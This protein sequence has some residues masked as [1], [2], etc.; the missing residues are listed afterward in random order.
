MSRV[1]ELL[2]AEEFIA[3]AEEFAA[4]PRPGD[5]DLL[6]E[7]LEQIDRDDEIS[8]LEASLAI[9]EALVASRPRQDDAHLVVIE[10]LRKLGRADDALAFAAANVD[11]PAVRAEHYQLLCLHGRL[12]QAEAVLPSLAGLPAAIGNAFYNL[13][14][15]LHGS[16]AKDRAAAL[17]RA[18]VAV[19]APAPQAA[20]NLGIALL[21]LGRFAEAGE[22]ARAALVKYPTEPNLLAN[23]IDAG[24]RSGDRSGLR[25]LL[26]AAANALGKGSRCK[27][28]GGNAPASCPAGCGALLEDMANAWIFLGDDRSAVMAIEAACGEEEP[29]VPR[30]RY[31]LARA[32]AAGGQVADAAALVRG[33]RGGEVSATLSSSACLA[34]MDTPPAVPDAGSFYSYRA[35]AAVAWAAG[36]PERAAGALC[37]ALLLDPGGRDQL[38]Q[39]ASW[40]ALRGREPS[41]PEPLRPPAVPAEAWWDAGDK[42]W[43]LGPRDKQNGA[44]K[45]FRP[46]GSCC[47]ESSRVD[48]K[49]HGPFL[50]FHE[51]GEVSQRGAFESGE[52]HGTR[53]W[54]A[55]DEATTENTRQD[56]MS[57]DIWASE[58]DYV[59]GRVVEIRH[60]DKAG[61]QVAADGTRYPE[62]PDAVEPRAAYY[63]EKKH[64]RFGEIDAEGKKRGVWRTWNEHGRLIKEESYHDDELHGPFRAFYGNGSLAAEGE[65]ADGEQ[66]G[67]FTYLRNPSP[68]APIVRDPDED[69]EDDDDEDHTSGF[70]FPLAGKRVVKIQQIDDRRHHYDAAGR[71]TL[72]DGRPL[73][74]AMRDPWVGPW[75]TDL[76]KVD[77]S[78]LHSAGGANPPGYNL[79]SYLLA[80]DEDGHE[81]LSD[82]A[83]GGLYWHFCHQGTVYSG[84]AAV[85]PFVIR[86]LERKQ[87]PHRGALCNFLRS[88]GGPMRGAYQRAQAE[89]P[90]EGWADFLGAIA[91]FGEGYPVYRRLLEDA[92]PRIRS[93][94]ASLLGSCHGQAE[95]AARTLSYRLIGEKDPGVRGN[96]LQSL[97]S[98]GADGVDLILRRSLGQGGI[99]QISAGIG[100]AMCKGEDAGIETVA[101]L[102][103]SLA[104]AHEL[105]EAFDAMPWSELNIYAELANTL[106][107]VGNGA[108]VLDEILPRLDQVDPISSISIARAALTIAQRFAGNGEDDDDD[109][110]D[111]DDRGD[112][113]AAMRKV[114]RAIAAAEAPWR[115][116]VNLSEVL[117]EFD[118]PADREELA[119]AAQEE[120]AASS[121]AGAS[122]TDDEDEPNFDGAEDGEDS[123]EDEDE[124]GD[125]DGDD[126]DSDG[127]GDSD[128]G[129][130][131]ADADDD[132]DE[133]EGEGADSEE[134]EEEEEEQAE[135][136]DSD[137]DAD[138][139]VSA[140]TAILESERSGDDFT[141]ELSSYTDV[142]RSAQGDDVDLEDEIDR[143]LGMLDDDSALGGLPR[144]TD[145]MAAPDEMFLAA[146]DPATSTSTTSTSADRAGSDESFL[147]NGLLLDDEPSDDP[148]DEPD[149]EPS[150][151]AAPE[152][153]AA[154]NFARPGSDAWLS[155][156]RKTERKASELNI[157][158][159][160]SIDADLEDD[161][162]KKPDADDGWNN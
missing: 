81:K 56:G 145:Q 9:A 24:V 7:A 53:R 150:D 152:G 50:R 58:M 43:V 74:E 119:L 47:N 160:G 110:D 69:D 161:D 144:A 112:G 115:F 96:I 1:A 149:D 64:W 33:K 16:G 137:A 73:D 63:P 121:R 27:Q 23:A 4:A 62:R 154:R 82:A 36:E 147:E 54:T 6:F 116:N 71:E 105:E 34:L 138:H 38:A 148:S 65:Y 99:E 129:W 37:A 102:A 123:D 134:E 79:L 41:G 13:G 10:C 77:W 31:A 85:I 17:Y 32:L 20:I 104:S 122:G 30:V 118:L 28:C 131:A 59:H 157:A 14:T 117:E 11:R 76:A 80:E 45:Y 87:Q 156:V 89:G 101:A 127:D 21:S 86:L 100:M 97:G 61:S 106:V 66:A 141:S 158:E 155:D 52:L 98:L 108:T 44:Y 113:G 124:D 126:D 49:P 153:A 72:F 25:T 162:D 70:T 18:A 26:P 19:G 42:E 35:Q 125:G 84:T 120:H 83:F 2:E 78:G 67:T 60:Y 68:P 95:A 29:P 92:E 140:V 128:D 48:G 107:Q 40:A 3:A 139:G 46:D 151:E 133:D 103:G 114:M 142:A 39:D 109:D 130:A 55:C 93:W 22:S 12:E 143:S 132:D 51:N 5:A 91:A 57:M 15:R 8:Q 146:L 159:L 88:T 75:L 136:E 135:A 111:D 94:A 90:D